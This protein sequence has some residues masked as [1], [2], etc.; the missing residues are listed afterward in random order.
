MDRA[1]PRLGALL[2]RWWNWRREYSPE[3]GYARQGGPNAPDDVLEQLLMNAIEMQIAAL[4]VDQQRAIDQLARD[5][6]LG[7]DNGGA[8]EGKRTLAA[9]ALLLRLHSAGVL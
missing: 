9:A 5:E 1:P 8:D 3:R 2:A 7:L 4:P 6:C